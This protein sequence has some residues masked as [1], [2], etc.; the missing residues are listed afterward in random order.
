M[1]KGEDLVGAY[2]LSL[3]LSFVL[4][5]AASRPPPS[6]LCPLPSD[7]FS[8]FSFTLPSNLA[9]SNQTR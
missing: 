1:K 6:V 8:H 9:W 7:L 4:L 3:S 5:L 2:V